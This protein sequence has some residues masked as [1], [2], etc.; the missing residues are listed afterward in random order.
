MDS[1]GHHHD[2]ALYRRIVEDSPAAVVL[3][4]ERAR[5]PGCSTRARGSRTSPALAVDELIADPELWLRHI[6]PDEVE[7]TLPRWAGA[8]GA[9]RAL[10]AEYRFLH[11]DG[12][13]AMAPRHVGAGRGADGSIRYR[14]SFIEDITVGAVRRGAGRA[15][16]G[17]VPS[18]RRAASGHR[19]RRLRRAGAPQSLRQPQLRGHPRLRAATSS[20]PIRALVRLDAP[21]RPS[22]VREAWA[23]SIRSRRPFQAEYRDLKPDGSVVW[24]RDH[25]IL[26]HDDEGKPAVLAG[27]AARRHRRE[28]GRDRVRRLRAPVPGAH[29]AAAGGGLSRRAPRRDQHDLRELA[30]RADDRHPR[31]AMDERAGTVG[32]R[33]PSRR[34]R[35]RRSKHGLGERGRLVAR[36]GVP[37]RPRRRTRRLGA[38]HGRTRA[39]PRRPAA[40]LARGGHRRHGAARKPRSSSPGPRPGTARSSSR[41][42]RSSTRWAPTTS[43]ARCSSRRTSRSCSAIRDRSGSTSPTSGPSCCTPT[44]AR[45]S[46][47]RTTCTTRPASRGNGNTG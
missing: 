46:S 43:D 34:R 45:P 19:L 7:R 5:R 23:E 18:A 38:R 37:V 22:R 42:P 26:V 11:R 15:I 21:R 31:R 13:M 10:T 25:S 17:E 16:R 4:V 24:V 36:H 39:R 9:A 44:I 41:S 6:D 12:R 3:A 20:W 8:V 32:A 47:P 2:E 29:R 1:S 14:Q 33:D 28:T 30:D 40:L 35:A 27:R